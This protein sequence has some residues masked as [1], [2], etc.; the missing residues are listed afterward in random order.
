MRLSLSDCLYSTKTGP[1]NV[2]PSAEK[3]MIKITTQREDRSYCNIVSFRRKQKKGRIRKIYLRS[4]HQ[5]GQPQ[6]SGIVR[7]A[8]EGLSKNLPAGVR[9]FDE[10]LT[11]NQCQL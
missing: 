8:I 3:E 9:W 2:D 6:P 11:H 5:I 10:Y 1:K 7:G 4:P